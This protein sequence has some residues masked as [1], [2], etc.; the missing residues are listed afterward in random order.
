MRA[1][2]ER[3]SIEVQGAFVPSSL[4]AWAVVLILMLL[5]TSSFIDRQILGLLVRPVRA[6]LQI[7][8]TE[9]SLL[10]GFAFVTLYSIAG[11]PLGWAVDRWSRRGI[12]V[13]GVTVWS[14][15]TAGCSLAG[16]F[17]RLFA[18]R[19]GVGI[20]EAT[21]SPASYSLISDYFP[22][23]KLS[24]ALSVYGLGIPIGT[25]LALVIGGTVVHAL[26]QLGPVDLPL[27]GVEKPWQLVFLAIGLPGLLLAALAGIAIREPPR[28]HCFASGRGADVPRFVEAISFMWQNRRLYASLFFGMGFLAVFSYGANAWYP[29][30]LQRVH[31]IDIAEAG[32]FLGLTTLV[33]GVA[34][35][36]TAGFVADKLIER[37]NLDGQFVVPMVYGV[38]LTLCGAIAGFAQATW[39]SLTFVALSAF[40]SNTMLGCVV[41]ALQVATPPRMRG[42]I[43]AFFLFTAAFIGIAIGPTAVAAATDYIFGNDHAVGHSLGLVALVFPLLGV[44][45]LHLGRRSMLKHGH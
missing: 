45:V 9:Y 28:H 4:Y 36:V 11:V 20:G 43:S 35:S 40:F 8:D 6:D 12:I 39:V 30:F 26:E 34:G 2:S 33:F 18:I 3:R 24:R 25:G 29:A 21:L 16:S 17:W 15:M 13:L 10:S 1:A 23:N 5:Y 38:A 27:L 7:S 14:L 22:A 42:Q 37:G 31:G 41:A 44:A 32:L 19:V